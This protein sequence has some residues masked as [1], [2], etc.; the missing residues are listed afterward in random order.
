MSCEKP[1]DVGGAFVFSE[2]T[3][4]HSEHRRCCMEDLGLRLRGSLEL[5]MFLFEFQNIACAC[6]PILFLPVMCR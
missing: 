1:L 2:S 5:P 3:A 4:W 6:E